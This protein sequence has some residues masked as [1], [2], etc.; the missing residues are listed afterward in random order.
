MKDIRDL[1]AVQVR[2]FPV[3]TIPMDEFS[4]PSIR[5]AIEE[6][7]GFRKD[8]PSI[9]R[10][11]PVGIPQVV[12]F[13]DGEFLDEGVRVVV[14]TVEINRRRIMTRISGTSDASDKFYEEFRE[15]VD[16]ITGRSLSG[17]VYQ[18]EETSCA[19]QLDIDLAQV[20]NRKLSRFMRRRLAEMASNPSIPAKSFVDRIS[21][22][23]EFDVRDENVRG[24]GITV[25]PKNF[26]I[27]PRA[28]APIESRIFSTS[29]PFR[30]DL[31]L[32]S[33]REFESY[34]G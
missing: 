3:D 14:R 32:Q 17:I 33:L 13:E 20:W 15:L 4:T 25:S 1:L 9:A 22:R 34:L 31:H 8:G 10:I 28:S 27:E 21:A 5:Q 2:L 19:A 29:S 16:S 6:A 30:S 7:F 23:I 26:V 24:H 11:R 18:A 12:T